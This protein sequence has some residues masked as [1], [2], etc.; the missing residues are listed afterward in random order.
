VLF[1]DGGAF[2]AEAGFTYNKTTD[3]ATLAGLAGTG[4]RVVTATPA[5]LMGTTPFG[6]SS[7]QV[8]DGAHTH[9]ALYQPLDSD[10]T[11][12]A[13]LAGVRGD[14]IFRDAT[15][16]QR[17][18]AGTAGQMLTTQG[19]AANPTWTTPVTDPVPQILMLGG[20]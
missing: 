11:A 17:L 5:G 4:T 13:A 8:S 6:T 7:G 12:F 18:G 15:Q 16:W 1:N 14:V 2:F 19:A 20:M 9:T 10:L 3:L